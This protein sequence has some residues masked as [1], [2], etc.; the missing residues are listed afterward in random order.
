MSR[1]VCVPH[2]RRQRLCRSRVS[3]TDQTF[4]VCPYLRDRKEKKGTLRDISQRKNDNVATLDLCCVHFNVQ[5]VF[6]VARET[7]QWCVSLLYRASP[8]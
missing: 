6:S 7:R 5:I 3:P 1:R 8:L 4:I 2:Y